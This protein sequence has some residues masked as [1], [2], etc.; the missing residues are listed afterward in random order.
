MDKETVV[1]THQGHGEEVA[2]PELKANPVLSG[3]GSDPGAQACRGPG[4]CFCRRAG[5]PRLGPARG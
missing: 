5:T 3:D 4:C 2:R 1:V